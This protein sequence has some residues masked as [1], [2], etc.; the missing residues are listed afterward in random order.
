MEMI[1][2]IS[3]DRLGIIKKRVERR[4]PEGLMSGNMAA[5]QNCDKAP[6]LGSKCL[7]QTASER[8]FV[9]SQLRKSRHEL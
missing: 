1:P 7:Q 4:V 6:L 8:L 2:I 9:V 3:S 5:F